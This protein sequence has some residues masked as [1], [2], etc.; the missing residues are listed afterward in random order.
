MGI[1][2]LLTPLGWVMQSKTHWWRK[3][4]A[5]LTSLFS[6]K[7]T[8]QRKGKGGRLDG[9]H[10]WPQTTLPTLS[11]LCLLNAW[12]RPSQSQQSSAYLPSFWNILT[13]SFVVLQI[14]TILILPLWSHFPQEAFS[15]CP[16]LHHSLPPS[17]SV[18]PGCGS[19]SA[20]FEN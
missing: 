15:C 8:A 20:V 11:F 19:D 3:Q 17:A 13:I 5:G 2:A 9:S 10:I 18:E 7:D 14:V 4:C 12:Q 6:V 1:S 16:S